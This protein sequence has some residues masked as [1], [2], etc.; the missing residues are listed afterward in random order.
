MH[1]LGARIFLAL[2]NGMSFISVERVSIFVTYILTFVT[3][4][5]ELH[6]VTTY[7]QYIDITREECSS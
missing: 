6:L 3:N 1:D 2:Y 4:I 5:T 7:A